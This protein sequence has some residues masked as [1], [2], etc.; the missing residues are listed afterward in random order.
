[1]TFACNHFKKLKCYQ[2]SF[3]PQCNTLE[4]E[5]Q[6]QRDPVDEK[7]RRPV[8]K[9]ARILVAEKNPK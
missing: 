5:E 2:K 4:G 1:M 7:Q 6:D 3:I 9:D 8:E